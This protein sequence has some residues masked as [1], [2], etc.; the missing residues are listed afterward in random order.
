MYRIEVLKVVGPSWLFVPENA[1]KRLE[2]SRYWSLLWSA[3]VQANLEG[4]PVISRPMCAIFQKISG[5]LLS[6]RL[7]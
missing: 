1:V 3:G 6:L 2:R 7:E 4:I 5:G